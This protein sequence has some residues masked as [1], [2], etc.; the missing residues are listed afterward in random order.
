MASRKSAPP[1]F[2][3]RP[4]EG[5]A[6]ESFVPELRTIST[7]APPPKVDASPPFFLRSHP[8][9]WTVCGDAIVPEFGRLV[10][11]A[12]VNGASDLGGKLDVNDARGMA[13]RKGWT[14][15][16][17]DCVPPEHVKPGQRPSYIY[18]PVGRPDVHLL[19]Y[20]R[21]YPGSTRIDR[22]E[23]GYLRFCAYLQER[24]IVPP[25]KLY[26]LEK[27]R[28]KLVHQ[29]DELRSKAAEHPAYAGAL[30]VAERHVEVCEAA[31]AAHGHDAAVEHGDAPDMPVIA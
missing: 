7:D 6:R 13:E 11:Q 3:E 30:Q 14:L 28:D 12:G 2:V 4:D 29:R 31:I 27:L 25:P 16:P 24:G 1:S 15:I 20:E 19:I 8:E 21:C 26:A 22:D 5:A 17:V 9:R 23:A 10:I 18:R